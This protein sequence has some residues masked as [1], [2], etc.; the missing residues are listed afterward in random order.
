MAPP[1][2]HHHQHQ[3][4]PA[5][6]AMGVEELERRMAAGASSGPGAPANKPGKLRLAVDEER[7]LRGRLGL[8]VGIRDILQG[9]WEGCGCHS[10]T[11]LFWRVRGYIGVIVMIERRAWRVVDQRGQRCRDS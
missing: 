8:L 11:T 3:P 1:T 5:R 10:L 7:G 2:D 6:E 9:I 4:G